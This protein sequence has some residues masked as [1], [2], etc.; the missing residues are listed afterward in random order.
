MDIASFEKDEEDPDYCP[1]TDDSSSDGCSDAMEID[2]EEEDSIMISHRDLT[3]TNS[4]GQNT[5]LSLLQKHK[6]YFSSKT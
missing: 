5:Y 4:S 3:C 2:P 6:K 1:S